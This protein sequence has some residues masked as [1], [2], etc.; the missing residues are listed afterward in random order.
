MV[1][2]FDWGNGYCQSQANAKPATPTANVQINSRPSIKP[3]LYFCIDLE[4]E[5]KQD[6][7]SMRFLQILIIHYIQYTSTEFGF[8]SSALLTAS[9]KAC[10]TA[11][12]S[13][14][15]IFNICH[16]FQAEKIQFLFF[17]QMI[18]SI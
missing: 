14:L 5:E 4:E 1:T 16:G 15:L 17:T 10:F 8:S 9:S 6:E 13:H 12:P 11:E 2:Y 3:K 18:K 7:N